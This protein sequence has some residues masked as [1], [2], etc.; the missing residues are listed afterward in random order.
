[1]TA[2]CPA[3][4][5]GW[6]AIATLALGAALA[7]CGAP[8]PTGRA[9]TSPPAPKSASFTPSPSTAAALMASWPTY[10]LNTRRSG[11]SPNTPRP[12]SPKVAW[13]RMLDGSVY[14]EPLDVG[15]MVIVAT[16]NDSL[17][18][19]NAASGSVIWTTHVGTPVPQSD[20]PCGDIFPLGIT[21]TPAFDLATQTL[22]AVAE[23]SGPVHVLYA[24]DAVSGAVRWSRRVD[25]QIASES[26]AAVQQRPALM[27]ANG[28]V[29]IGF[30]GLDG[31]CAQYRGAVVAVPTSDSGPTLQYV[32]PTDREGAV[33]ASGGP[34]L[35]AGGNIFVSTGNGAATANPWDHSDSVL[36]LSPTL[37]LI[38][39]FAPSSWAVDNQHDLDLGSVAPTLLPDGYVFI[40]GKSGT[41]YVLRQSS[42][43][44]VGGRGHER[45]DLRWSDG[46][47]GHV[48]LRRHGVSALPERG[49]SNRCF[50]LRQ[51]HCSMADI[52]RGQWSTRAGR[53]MRLERRHGFGRALRPRPGHG[54]SNRPGLDRGSSALH[55]PDAGQRLGVRRH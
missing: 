42:L 49:R 1:M 3:R 13:E 36:E 55:Q 28:Y 50:K 10:H 4:R 12:T 51:V 5:G 9:S 34:V 15:G 23:E 16:E 45:P 43:G 21:G 32:V 2:V 18:A 37:H 26:P 6:V 30:G 7:A 22:F 41:G 14:A 29:Y 40:A 17:Y 48:L 25:I 54:E 20:L 44:G 47:W 53:W 27:V 35:A 8:A 24:F 52:E 38:S 31:D 46:L 33:W 39:A 11:N 19:L